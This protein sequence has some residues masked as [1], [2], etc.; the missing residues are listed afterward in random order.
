MF[1]MVVCGYAIDPKSNVVDKLS[2]STT[3]LAIVSAVDPVTS[4]VC[5][6]LLTFALLVAISLSI[7]SKF[8]A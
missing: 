3:P 8:T 2:E 6:A 4:P 1:G 7:V 5:V